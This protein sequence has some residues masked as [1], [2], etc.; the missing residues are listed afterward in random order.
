[1]TDNAALL[2]SIQT[3]NDIT[4]KANNSCDQ[5]CMMD[6]QKRDLKNAYLDAERNVKTAP[7][8]F[9]EAEHS[10]LLHKEGTKGYTE[11]LV[12]R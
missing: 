9:S 4:M 12:E 8:K 10:Y 3:I 5:D 6:R 2:Q 11:L 1:M 7:E